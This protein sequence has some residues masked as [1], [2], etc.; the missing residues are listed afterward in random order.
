MKA[1]KKKNL[2]QMTLSDQLDYRDPQ[3][4]SEFAQDIYHNMRTEEVVKK[5][6]ADYLTKVQ[7]EIK[8]TS[9]AFLIEW[10]IDV[11]RKFRLVPEALYVAINIID[12]YMSRKRIKKNQLHLLGVSTLLIAAK[13]EEIYPP[14]LSDFITVSENKFTKQMVLQMEKD[15]LMTLNFDLTTPSAYRFL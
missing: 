1:Y 12:Q 11:H 15:I 8:D 3:N 13:Y 2:P 10:I 6:P 5:V 4:L 14:S 9:R 7:T